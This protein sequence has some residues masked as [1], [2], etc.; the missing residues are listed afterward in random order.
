MIK[1]AKPEF[2]LS[3]APSNTY[4]KKIWDL[5]KHWSFDPVMI[6]MIILNIITMGLIYW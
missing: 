2:N 1:K 3:K 4:R 6:L 5:I